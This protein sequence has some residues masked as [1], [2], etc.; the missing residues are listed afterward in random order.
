M[1]LRNELLCFSSF[2]KSPICFTSEKTSLSMRRHRFVQSLVGFFF[3][4]NSRLTL[5]FIQLETL[6]AHLKKK[7][8][9]LPIVMSFS[10]SGLNVYFILFLR[11]IYVYIFFFCVFVEVRRNSNQTCWHGNK[12]LNFLFVCFL[13]QCCCPL[14]MFSHTRNTVDFCL[15]YLFC[16]A[17][18]KAEL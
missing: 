7:K 13:N 1:E 11:Y 10:D 17:M 15:I 4:S 3:F 12:W 8:L 18:K 6:L 9:F 14:K 2:S 5:I 16:I